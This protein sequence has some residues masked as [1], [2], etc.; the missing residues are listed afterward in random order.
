MRQ[1]HLRSYSRPLQPPSPAHTLL[2][3]L[4]LTYQAYMLM[5]LLTTG[6]LLTLPACA[7][8]RVM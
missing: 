6:Q 8:C 7:L 4:V 2:L 1:Q 5:T 3:P